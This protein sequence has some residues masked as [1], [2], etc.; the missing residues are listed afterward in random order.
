MPN[1]ISGGERQRVSIARSMIHNPSVILADEPTASLDTQRAFQVTQ[2][3]SE[4]IHENGKAGIM[5]THDLRMC[6]YVDKIIQIADGKI[7]SVLKNRDEIEALI[8]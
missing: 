8:S 2:T 4:L 7:T 1:Q 6:K 5:V 3:Y